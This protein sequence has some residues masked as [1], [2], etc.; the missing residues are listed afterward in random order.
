MIT[1]LQSKDCAGLRPNYS[2]NQ[3]PSFEIHRGIFSLPIRVF[4]VV[5]RKTVPME[6]S[7]KNPV[8]IVVWAVVD[9]SRMLVN[10]YTST[11][12]ELEKVMAFFYHSTLWSNIILSRTLYESLPKNSMLHHSSRHLFIVSDDMQYSVYDPTGTTYVFSSVTAAIEK[13][14]TAHI[15]ERNALYPTFIISGGEG[16]QDEFS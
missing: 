16:T 14:H 9:N 12:R 5:F 2:Y 1:T 11:D 10:I 3:N 6:Q 13:I 4:A 15:E 7:H 8:E